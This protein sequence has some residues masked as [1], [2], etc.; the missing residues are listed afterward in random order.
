MIREM[1]PAVPD[2]DDRGRGSACA[3][4]VDASIS[5]NVGTNGIARIPSVYIWCGA[6]RRRSGSPGGGR[7]KRSRLSM[8]R[9][10]VRAVSVPQLRRNHQ[11]LRKLRRRVV[12]Q[13][14]LFRR[15][16]CA[17]GRDAMM[18]RQSRDATRHVTVAT[19]ADRRF[20]GCWIVNASGN[21]AVLS[22]ASV[23]AHW[24]IRPRGHDAAPSKTTP[25]ARHH[26]GRR[27]RERTPRR[28]ESGRS[29][30]DGLAPKAA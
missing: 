10:S 19:A 21:S 7:M 5:R 9:P 6:G 12:T 20:A 27:L 26:H 13:Q 15:L 24:S 17:I 23:G 3:R 14:K 2:R 22:R 16:S 11:G 29:A 30:V 1:A 18:R 8:P 25:R 28:P 4:A